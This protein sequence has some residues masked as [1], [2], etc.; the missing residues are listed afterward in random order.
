MVIAIIALLISI[1]LPALN[2]AR[3]QAVVVNCESNLRQIGIACINYANDNKGFL[4]MR[5]EY[6]TDNTPSKGREAFID[7][8]FSYLVESG[9]DT[10]AY[11]PQKV[12]GLGMLWSMGYIK[13]VPALYCPADL[14]DPSFGYNAMA[15]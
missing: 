3:E 6:W 4:P 8:F 15:N 2:R 5:A 9:N 12:V 10:R 11:D 1:L 7:P 13:S 14:D